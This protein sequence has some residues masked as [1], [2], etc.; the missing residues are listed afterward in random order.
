MAGVPII[1]IGLDFGTKTVK[2]KE[3]FYPSDDVMNDFKQIIGFFSS[4]KGIKPER[5]ITNEVFE[6]MKEELAGL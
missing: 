4:C 1:M 6:N 2:I 3:P 5:G